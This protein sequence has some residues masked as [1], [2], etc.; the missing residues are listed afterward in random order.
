M[1]LIAGAS[2]LVLGLPPAWLGAQV[3]SQTRGSAVD[4]GGYRAPGVDD[5][6]AVG[7]AGTLPVSPGVLIRF[8]GL[9]ELTAGGVVPPSPS[10]A[11]GVSR[12]I[13]AANSALRLSTVTGA[14]L[15]TKTLRAFFG[16]PDRG[17]VLDPQ[18]LF[19]QNEADRRFYIAALQH[20]GTTEASGTSLIH[21]AVSRSPEPPDLEP[22]H[23]CRYAIDAKRDGGTALASR[24]GDLTLTVGSARLVL[25][26][27]QYRFATNAFTFA[28]IRV[29]DK[30]A[31]SR[32]TGACPSL[33]GTVVFQPAAAPGDRSFFAL[34]P[35]QSPGPWAADLRDPV[36]FVNT[37]FT[38]TSSDDRYRVSRIW[39]TPPTFRSLVLRGARRYASPP[40]SPQPRSAVR[41][42]TGDARIRQ[43]AGGRATAEAITV[44]YLT[45]VHATRCHV[46]AASPTACV[47]WVRVEVTPIAAAFARIDQQLMLGGGPG[48]FD[49]FPGVAEGADGVSVVAFQRSGPGRFLHG[50]VM[51]KPF[52]AEAFGPAVL[53]ATPTG[54]CALA[55]P[56]AMGDAI[57]V[58]RD[59]VRL[60]YWVS[61]VRAISVAGRCVWETAVVNLRP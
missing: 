20:R 22:D 24:A 34:Q 46:G 27:D 31:L 13:Q 11:K 5:G 52:S 10:V 28:V 37:G 49:S 41:L 12:V 26:T 1:V 45:A 55:A 16:A 35:V 8:A 59:P 38:G 29:L 58:R 36:Y 17:A 33:P 54:Q 42:D 57:T 39:D 25:T 19:D 6:V 48:I 7:E 60:Q 56:R 40:D 4:A 15:Q 32:N 18:V 3:A 14:P 51:V 43:A 21:L 9:D 30:V 61:T 47:M 44:T 23:W 2:F 53:P 50:L